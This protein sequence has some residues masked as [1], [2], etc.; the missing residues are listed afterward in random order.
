M[1]YEA[2]LLAAILFIAA[3]V[4]LRVFPNAGAGPVKLLFQL[5][6]LAIAASY[7]VFCWSRGGT[8]P[9]KTWGM[10]LITQDCGVITRERA[11]LR[12]LYALIGIT[13]LGLG[14][15]WALFDRDRQFLHDRLAGTRIGRLPASR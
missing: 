12:F 13:A 11:L 15:V 8:L 9:M 6:L 10:R 2:L 3:F 5:Y 14:L 7:F 1:I 4:F